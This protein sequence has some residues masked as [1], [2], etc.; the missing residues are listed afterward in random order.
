MGV[1][2]SSRPLNKGEYVV[3]SLRG[4]LYKT[5]VVQRQYFRIDGYDS[6]TS[7]TAIAYCLAPIPLGQIKLEYFT[8]PAY[9]RSID[10]GSEPFLVEYYELNT[11]GE[12]ELIS[13][14]E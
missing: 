10:S 11:A 14:E 1:A 2:K 12:L 5:P 6:E 4:V 13:V 9:T 7:N 8:N 3:A